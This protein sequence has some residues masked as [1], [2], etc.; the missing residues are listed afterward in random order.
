MKDDLKEKWRKVID[1]HMPPPTELGIDPDVVATLLA[2]QERLER[3]GIK[4]KTIQDIAREN[5]GNHT[6]RK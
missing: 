2:N 3:R 6:R 4:P 1:R 5:F